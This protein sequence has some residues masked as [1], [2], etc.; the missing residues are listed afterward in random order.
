MTMRSR[1]ALRPQIEGLE[2]RALLSAMPAMTAHVARAQHHTSI[3]GQLATAPQMTVSTVPSNGD[4]N[5]YGIAVVPQGFA[6]GG[7]LRPG[8]ILVSNFNGSSNLQGTGTTIVKIAPDGTQSLFFQ[9]NPGIG[10]T[11][12]LGVL[13]GGF[14]LVGN[15][16]TTDGTSA[17]IQPGS[18]L[19]INR[20]GQQVGTISDS[21]LL[22]GPW[23][24]TVND[25]GAHPQVFVSNVLSGT[26]TRLD[27]QITNRGQQLQVVS[28]T[29]IASGYAHRTDPAALVIGPTGLAFDPAR[30][31][32]YVASTGDNAIYAVSNASNTR[33]DQ[34]TG[35]LVYQDNTHLH[36]PLG[37]V[38]APN[39]DLIV[40]NGD[41]VNSDPNQPSEIVEFTPAGQFVAQFSLDPNFDAPF[42]I[43]LAQQGRNVVFAA[44]ND[45]HNTVELFHVRR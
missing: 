33:Q 41:A 29:Q 6:R 10:L 19:V 9:G 1:N 17:T 34:G 13:R 26:V 30:N 16:P 21:T 25:R 3:V 27:L 28:K 45:N 7:A 39:G 42:G 22:N 5:P 20:F 18:I 14:V 2:M 8:D 31:T 36:G 40:A 37:L 15:T 24:L 32:L 11:T 38:R 23:D 35:R 4:L 44:V 43:A 12:A